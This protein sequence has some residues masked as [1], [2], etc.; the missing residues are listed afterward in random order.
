MGKIL[1]IP[2]LTNELYFKASI[3]FLLFL[4]LTFDRDMSMIY[5][6]ILVGDFMW[7]RFD[8]KISF[9]LEKTTANRYS[10]LIE[11]GIAT[12]AFFIFSSL[13]VTFAAVDIPAGLQSILTLLST[14]TPILQGNKMLTLI[15]WGV[16][17]PI[18]ETSFFNGRLLE[19][20]ASFAEKRFHKKITLTQSNLFS[21]PVIMVILVVAAFFTLF[22]ITAKNLSSVPLLITFIFSCISSV[23]VIRHQ[24]LKQAILIH[25]IVNS[26]AVLSSFGLLA[27]IGL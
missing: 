22:H 8:P 10:S 9:P 26:M 27:F 5:I 18:I 13:A 24:E 14:S 11:V 16:L 12:A 3:L 15:G 25:I 6:L 17:I 23:L 7:Y 1:N 20:L 19:G 4:L 21:I 2:R